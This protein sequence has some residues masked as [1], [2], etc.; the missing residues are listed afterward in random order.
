MAVEAVLC[1]SVF[2]D[3]VES[4]LLE[5]EATFVSKEVTRATRFPTTCSNL[6]DLG[7]LGGHCLSKRLDAIFDPSRVLHEER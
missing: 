2:Q 3:L 6:G 5:A 4:G 1:P 7:S